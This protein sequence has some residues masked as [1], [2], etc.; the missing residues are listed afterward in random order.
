[1]LGE[2]SPSRYEQ[3]WQNL[4]AEEKIFETS[5]H[6]G[7]KPTYYSLMMF[8][9]P[10]GDLHMGHACNYTM[11][12][13]ISRYRKMRGF[14][15]LHPM[16]W[17]ALGLPAENA[18]IN[19]GVHPAVWTQ[20]NV[21]NM[22]RQLRMAGLAYDWPREISTAHP[23]YY[24]WTQWIFLK[25]LEH[26][27]AYKREALVNWDPVDGTVLAN[28]QIHDGIAW[29]SGAKVEKR[30]LSQWFLKITDYAQRLLD[31]LDGLVGWPE[32][33]KQQ[34]RNWLGRSEGA[35]I[36]FKL[37]TTGETLSV[38]TTRPDT[39]YGVTFMVCAPEHPLIDQ[40]LEGNPR[41]DSIREAVDAMQAQSTAERMSEESEKT[42]ID[43]GHFIINPVNGD[44]VPLLVA[45]YALMEYGTGIVMGVPAHDQR[46][47]LFARKYGIPVKVVIQHPEGGLDG[48]TM[49]EAYIEDGVM[50]NSGPF[51]RQP[52]RE[53]YPKMIDYF[54]EKGFGD[55][56]IN[57]RLRD[58]L[59]SRQRYWGVPIPVIYEE[60]DSITPVPDDHLPVMHPRDV[61]FTGRG[62]NPLEKSE[63]FVNVISPKTGR[64]ARR[65]TDTMDT[66]VDSSWYYLRYV[67][68][69]DECAVFRSENVN[70]WLPVT[71]YIGG[72]EHAVMHL[73]YSRFFT[74]V[75]YD[76]GLVSFEEPFEN[77]FTQGMVCRMA[78]YVADARGRVW[79]PYQDVDEESFVVT[80]DGPS[81]SGYEAGQKVLAEMASMSKSKMNG[82]S[83]EECTGKYG[84]D[85]GRLYTL[86]I[87][88]PERSK[89]WRDDGLIGVH[90]F[91]QRLWITFSERLE[92]WRE[93]SAYCGDGSG[94]SASG[95]K[96]RRDAHATLKAVTEVYENTF[97]FNTA[98]AR[99]MELATSL[100]SEADAENAVQREA[101]EILL[102]CMAPMAPHVAE[103]LWE[104]LRADEGE[105]SIFREAWPE[106]DE[107][108]IAAEEK[109]FAVQVNGKTRR[110][111]M[112][113][114]DAPE[115]ELKEKAEAV[116]AG[117]IGDKEIVKH[118]VVPGRLVN[119]IV[120]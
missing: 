72:A 63:D 49:E 54:A 82:V 27:L 110:T 25:M 112:A 102:R 56:T 103:E 39:V 5:D 73:L 107:A 94:L 32:H 43:T 11:G 30:W 1:M 114:P 86:F 106:V 92:G 88:P 37:E 84:A 71:Q 85:A 58:W 3:K 109:E 23:G 57:W 41:A 36:D 21:D 20:K 17:D 113:L 91:L 45:D 80:A 52:N 15:V 118:I 79:V 14:E 76:L 51:D 10:S 44:R 69:R 116:T 46:D 42:G 117:Y 77:L 47:F 13:A 33:V 29:R 8:P 89:E 67:S 19:A 104:A 7:D 100:R 40:L 38:F 87:G 2:Y 115:E 120:K 99:I 59:I 53:A 81:G 108:A 78:Y 35:R 90:R 75:L 61:K 96:L 64:P 34:Q 95:R 83:I 98:V 93:T 55:K 12:D 4:W 111:F 6:P 97:S 9:Y 18:A 60:D 24:R 31:D 28:E 26:G 48:D 105:G 62:G 50:E 119:L 66:F 22:R 65:E 74:K 70:R 16:G 68:P 101:A